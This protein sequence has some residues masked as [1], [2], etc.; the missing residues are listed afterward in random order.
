MKKYRFFKIFI[1]NIIYKMTLNGIINTISS[2]SENM[3]T[4]VS[5]TITTPSDNILDYQKI[6]YHRKGKDNYGRKN[7][8]VINKYTIS[9]KTIS[10]QIMDKLLKY[11]PLQINVPYSFPKNT[12][13]EKEFYD[14]L[15]IYYEKRLCFHFY[16]CYFLKNYTVPLMSEKNDILSTLKIFEKFKPSIITVPIWM[17]EWYENNSNSKPKG[18][19]SF[20]KNNFTEN[21]KNFLE[22]YYIRIPINSIIDI[23]N[24]TSL[25]IEYNNNQVD[26]A[27]FFISNK[28]ERDYNHI[29]LPGHEKAVPLK[30]YYQYKKKK[31]F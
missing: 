5:P 29:K 23:K 13:E 25:Y 7:D 31:F 27:P 30:K 10:N 6:Y 26:V 2:T 17:I 8:W 15:S 22:K 1:I 16:Q 4:E 3:L 21:L 24:N 19:D 28:S 9:K 11:K 18:N 20:F 14:L 12:P